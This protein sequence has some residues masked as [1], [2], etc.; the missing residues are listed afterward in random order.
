MR[1]QQRLIA[2]TMGQR[3]LANEAGNKRLTSPSHLSTTRKK[4]QKRE[5]EEGTLLEDKSALSLCGVLPHLL[6]LR[7]KKGSLPIWRNHSVPPP[8]HFAW[9]T[10]I[11]WAKGRGST[12]MVTVMPS[13]YVVVFLLHS[14][15]SDHT[16]FT[17][18]CS[19]ICLVFP[20]LCLAKIEPISGFNH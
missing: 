6:L 7:L 2:K 20:Q 4:K 14:F 12:A 11:A 10:S 1:V 17:F 16:T 9:K 19:Q 3:E 18:K 13:G 8:T 5:E 15:Y